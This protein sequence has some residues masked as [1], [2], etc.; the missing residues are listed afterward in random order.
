M[1]ERA[2]DLYQAA[3]IW[4]GVPWVAAP[5]GAAYALAGRTAEA[6][7]LLEQ[8]VEQGVAMRLMFDHALRVAWLSGGVSAGWPTGRGITQ[9]QG[10]HRCE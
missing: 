3:H 8:A 6:L 7:P 4:I 9:A 2:L 5:S 1:L 10:G